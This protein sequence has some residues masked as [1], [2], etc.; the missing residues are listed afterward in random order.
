MSMPDEMDPDDLVRKRGA[1]AFEKALEAAVPL[2][3]YKLE[4]AWR[5]SG[6]DKVNGEEKSGK[7]SEP[8][9]KTPL[10]C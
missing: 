7:R 1:E 4:C 6:A 8:L 3:D 5:E 9:P 10:P 2:T